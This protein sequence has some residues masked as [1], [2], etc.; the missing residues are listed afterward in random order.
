MTRQDLSSRRRRISI[1]TARPRKADL[2]RAKAAREGLAKKPAIRDGRKSREVTAVRRHHTVSQFGCWR[3]A[4]TNTGA[5]KVVELTGPL[6]GSAG[7]ESLVPSPILRQCRS[8]APWLLKSQRP[9]CRA[10][11][12]LSPCAV[13][14]S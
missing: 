14:R 13:L 8:D 7:D 4:R 5:A 12:S 9:T 3:C 6:V 11:P 1:R 2:G 10:M